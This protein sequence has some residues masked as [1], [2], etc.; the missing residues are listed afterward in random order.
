MKMTD[1][2]KLARDKAA[3]AKRDAI[4]LAM[5]FT[6]YRSYLTSDLWKEIRAKVLDRDGG[7]C[8]VCKR[9]ASSVHHTRYTE[10]TMRGTDLTGLRSICGR[11][12][13]GIEFSRHGKTTLRAANKRMRKFT[14]KQ[15]ASALRKD[16]PSF[17][18][19]E[20]AIRLERRKPRSA[21]RFARMIAIRRLIN[22]R[23][24]ARINDEPGFAAG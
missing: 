24:K 23:I 4:L 3:Y 8:K 17:R 15:A 21:E 1:A 2:Q 6:S 11:C 13:R 16:D 20:Q 5:G 7:A 14:K 18:E 19:L 12:H 22:Q 10:A 9:K